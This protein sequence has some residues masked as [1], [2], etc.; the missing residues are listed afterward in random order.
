VPSLAKSK[1]SWWNSKE[2]NQFNLQKIFWDNSERENQAGHYT[3]NLTVA[4]NALLDPSKRRKSKVCQDPTPSDTPSDSDTEL[5]GP[6]AD[7]STEEDE[8]QDADCVFCIG[9][10]SEH[11]NGKEWIRCAKYCRRANTLCAG[12]EKDFVGET[13]QG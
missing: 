5:A 6:L 2:N 7:E 3:E 1:T 11:H 12:M 10:L 13:C 8:E 4:S 9:R